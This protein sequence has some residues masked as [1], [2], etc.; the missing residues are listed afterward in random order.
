MDFNRYACNL[1]LAYLCDVQNYVIDPI[2]IVNKYEKPV[3]FGIGY[4]YYGKNY[5][6]NYIV[7]MDM[8]VEDEYV[9]QIKVYIICGYRMYTNFH[10][11]MDAPYNEVMLR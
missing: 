9:K 6:C 4:T 10:Y 2:K 3:A 5:S 7:D 8:N 1:F 11:Q